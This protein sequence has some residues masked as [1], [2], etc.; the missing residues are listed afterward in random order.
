VFICVKFSLVVSEIKQQTDKQPAS[1]S[2]Y[3]PWLS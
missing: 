3:L 2:G 1:L